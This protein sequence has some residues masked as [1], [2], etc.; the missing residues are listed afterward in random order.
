MKKAYINMVMSLVSKVVTVITGLVLQRQ[1]LVCYGSSLNGLTSSISQ[2]MSYLVLLES[3]LGLATIQVLYRP[4]IIKDENKVNE[5]L[6]TS[7]NEYKK[8]A[9]IF[10]ALLLG[11][12]C[13]F[14]FII[15]DDISFKIVFGLTFI[16]GLN[17]VISYIFGSKYKA[18]LNADQKIYVIQI[19]DIVTIICSCILRII[20]IK[21]GLNI[22]YVQIIN[23]MCAI[24][25]IAGL[26]I[27]VKIKYK[28]LDTK[29]PVNKALLKKR[30][31][32]LVH[33]LAG[34]VVNQTDI[35]ILTIFSSLKTVSIYSV[36][37][38]VF[39]QLSTI[40]QTTFMSA[41]QSTFGELYNKDKI[42]FKKYYR[43][44]EY[45]YS[46]LLFIVCTIAVVM[47]IPF[48]KIYTEGIKDT[49]YV[50]WELPLLFMIILFMNQIRIPMLMTIN[51]SGKFKET[52]NGAILEAVINIVVSLFLFFQTNLGLKGLLIGTICS[53][54]FRTLD[55]II[56]VYHNILED[57]ITRYIKFIIVN[58]VIMVGMIYTLYFRYPISVSGYIH[59]FVKAIIIGMLTVIIYI[60]TNALLFNNQFREICKYLKKKCRIK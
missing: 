20:A 22:I 10:L 38:M 40:L 32:V 47:I 19:L 51:I 9:G 29:I 43:M 17:Y 7:S 28:Y 44:Y 37:N 58:I 21:N 59:W 18:L 11:I 54:L 25:K 60:F 14:P 36:Y 4:L 26:N 13:L 2:I 23:V 56:Y 34:I 50:Y 27:Y 1:L 53:Y 8:I 41:P 6:N 33:N 48:V 12:S 15:K 55:I 45:V 3:G 57:K 5:I 35:M 42:A 52:Q 24:A 30:W 31:N 46:I 39:G 49:S 16:T